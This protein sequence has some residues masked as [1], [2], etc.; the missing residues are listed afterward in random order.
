MCRVSQGKFCFKSLLNNPCPIWELFLQKKNLS[1]NIQIS[2]LTNVIEISIYRII[3]LLSL[4]GYNKSGDRKAP[5][6]KK[7]FLRRIHIE[8]NEFGIT[9]RYV[10]KAL[11]MIIEILN[12]IQYWENR[13]TFFINNPS[14][15]AA[16]LKL[17]NIRILKN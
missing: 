3:S 10:L 4:K 8:N 17:H 7:T 9:C 1:Q 16:T 12:W 15:I 13:F 5:T 14:L 2:S 11:V 6:R